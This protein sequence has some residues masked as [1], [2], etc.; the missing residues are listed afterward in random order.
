MKK[1]ITYGSYDLFHKGHYNL[2]K[3]AK[4]LGDY[5]IVGVTTEYYDITRGKLNV[6]DSLLER[7]ENVKKTGFADEIIIEDH[8]GQKIEDIIKYNIDIFTVGSDWVGKFDYLNQY[9]EVVYLERTKDIS[10]TDLR[11]NRFPLIRLGMIG[12]G[13]I[14]Y[15]FPAEIKYVSGIHLTS[16]YNPRMSSAK[17]YADEFQLAYACNDLEDFYKN[18]DAVNI[19][20]PHETHYQYIMDA[21]SRDKHV[22]CEKPMVLSEKHAR[23]VYSFAKEK[24]LVLMEGI[25]TAYMPGFVQLIGMVRNGIIGNVRD[26]EA[27]FTKLTPNN[28]REM[29][30]VKYGG[31]FTELASY[32]LLPIIKIFG[33]NYE[34]INFDSINA[35]NG[36][37]IYTKAYIRYKHGMA[38]VKT[39]L[40]V[41]SEGQLVIAGTKGYILVKSPWWRIEGFEICYEDTLKN[42]FIQT[43]LDGDGLRYEIADF[44]KCINKTYRNSESKLTTDESIGIAKIMEKFIENNRDI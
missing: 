29:T 8:D 41:K 7:I 38:T 11:S 25:K 10:S 35:D 28:L 27:C 18:I 30:D 40:G 33:T 16:V 21:L 42:R 24:K 31:S 23:E 9:C 19:A 4:E 13:R 37:D 43:R 36:I 6:V 44:V 17:K 26:V 12:T 15:R 39:G 32:N 34:K 5:L 14:A 2:L 20:S 3:R 1:V 22:I